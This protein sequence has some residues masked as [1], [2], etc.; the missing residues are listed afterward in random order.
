MLSPT[1]N[2]VITIIENDPRL[3]GVL[4]FNQFTQRAVVRRTIRPHLTTAT[5]Y[6]CRDTTDGD[7]LQDAHVTLIRVILEASKSALTGPYRHYALSVTADK[8]IDAIERSAANHPFHPVREYIELHEW[9]GTPRIDTLLIDHLGCADTAYHREIARLVMVASVARIYE[10]GCKFDYAI[11]IQG[12]TGIRKSSF[13]KALYTPRWTGELN[14]RLDNQQQIAETIMGAWA[15][16]LPELAGMHKSEVNDTKM[17]MRRQHDDVR[18][19][20]GHYVEEFPRQFIP[21][22]TTNDLKYLKDS[23]GNRSFW[24]VVVNVAMIDTDAVERVRDQ[25]WAE[26]FLAYRDMRAATP[27]DAELPFLLTRAALGEAEDRQEVVRSKEMHEMWAENIGDW[28]EEPI[29]RS[30][31]FGEFDIA[32]KFTEGEDPLVLRVAF[33]RN[34]AVEIPLKKE[35]GVVDY[36]TAQNIEKALP[37]ISGWRDASRDRPYVVG[38]QLR[39]WLRVDITRDELKQGYRDIL[40]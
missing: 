24:P 8:R 10:P 15:E 9:D 25:L 16:E 38:K 1:V 11:I 4:T 18:L 27:K 7:R 17:F 13:I 20:W 26:A 14:C 3:K 6:R 28:L 22:G 21:W 32:A 23:T 29:R 33:T 37:L 12:K 40:I 31:L 35:R 39:W 36:P 19:A 2:N 30:T 34:Q 5:T